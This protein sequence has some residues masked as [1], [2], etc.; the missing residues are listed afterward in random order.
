DKRYAGGTVGV[1]AVM[2]TWTGQLVYHPHVHCLVTGGG[3]SADGASWCPARPDYLAPTGALANLAR[4]KPRAAL[5][6][7]RPALLIPEAGWRKPWVVHCTAWGTGADAVLEYLA[8]YVYRVAITNS[9]IIGLNAAGVTIRHRER[10]SGRVLHTRLT[11]HEFMRRFLQHVLPKGLH[12]IRYFCLLHPSQKTQAARAGLLLQ[13]DR[14]TDPGVPASA[15]ETSDDAT[16]RSPASGST[17]EARICPICKEGRLV[18]IGRLYPKQA[19][20]P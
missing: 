6:R 7:Q 9:R 19:S 10:A 20:G 11:G 8:R 4:G 3:V 13:L 12:T 17:E 14:P 5:A 16:A 1:L 2:H 15:S 18:E